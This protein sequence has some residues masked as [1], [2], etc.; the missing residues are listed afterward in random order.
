MFEGEIRMVTKEK[1]ETEQEKD[2][3]EEEKQQKKMME[4]EREDKIE[5]GRGTKTQ[6]KQDCCI[7]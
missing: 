3:E 2:K 1:E 7:T 6:M 4:R 5:G